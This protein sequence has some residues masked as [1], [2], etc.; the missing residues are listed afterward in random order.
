MAKDPWIICPVC[1]GDGKTV[2]PAIDANGLTA[3][4]FADDPDFAD[5]Y[6]GGVYDIACRACNGTGKLRK[7]DKARLAE[8]AADRRLAAMEDG[9]FEGYSVAHDYRW[10]Y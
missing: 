8:A 3:D 6:L 2:N 10:G 4:D 1:D 5:D 7:S 9:D